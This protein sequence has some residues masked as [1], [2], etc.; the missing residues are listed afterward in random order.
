MI[1]HF[2]SCVGKY[3]RDTILSP[4]F[5]TLEVLMEILIPL[6]MPI[7]LTRASIWAT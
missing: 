2:L 7:S 5:I 3:K 6:Y 4:I 1:K